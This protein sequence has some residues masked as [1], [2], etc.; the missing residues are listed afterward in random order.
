MSRQT[1]LL[2]H[3]RPF[4]GLFLY[5]RLLAAHKRGLELLKAHL[6]RR[7]LHIRVLSSRRDLRI[8][9]SRRRMSSGVVGGADA[10]IDALPSARR[11]IA[12]DCVPCEMDALILPD[13]EALCPLPANVST[14]A[15]FPKERSPPP[16]PPI[17]PSCTGSCPIRSISFAGDPYGTSFEYLT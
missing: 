3:D 12:S 8:A 14:L 5:H 16:Y 17:L 11:G 4:E 2:T 13:A 6:I 1:A 10:E 15:S 7:L 9:P